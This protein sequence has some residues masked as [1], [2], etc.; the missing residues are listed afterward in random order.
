MQAALTAADAGLGRSETFDGM[1]LKARLH[2]SQGETEDAQ[3]WYEKAYNAATDDSDREFIRIR[4][5][6][7]NVDEEN[8]KALVDLA[9][10]RD[11]VFQNR[12]GVA[13]ALLGHA[14][15]ALDLYEIL[16]DDN[17]IPRRHIRLSEWALVAEDFERAQTEA[18]S[19]YQTASSR[20]DRLYSLALLSEAYRKPEA[21]DSLVELLSAQGL[22]NEELLELRIDIMVELGRFQEAIDLYGDIA[23]EK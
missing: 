2:D 16:P 6:M 12:A 14:D 13:L 1:L 15:E 21:L 4:L 9:S 20:T 10:E 11:Q 18:W 22:E 3:A 5:T 8:V 7:I 17:K 23:T 19:A